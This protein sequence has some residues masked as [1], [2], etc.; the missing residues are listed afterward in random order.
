VDEEARRR[1]RA[2]RLNEHVK[3]L[4]TTAN[5]IA[6]IVFGGGVLQPLLVQTSDSGVGWS[7]VLISATLHMAAHAV[8][9]LMRPE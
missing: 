4:V 8:I 6:L 3:L 2:K 1:L 9:R 7:W 5:A